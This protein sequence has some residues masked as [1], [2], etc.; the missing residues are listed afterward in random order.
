MN[1]KPAVLHAVGVH[2]IHA[3]LNARNA[4]GNLRESLR[5]QE[6]LFFVEWAMVRAH[7]LNQARLQR[8]PQHGQIALVAQR[9]RHNVLHAFHS[10]ALSVTLVE[11]KVGQHRFDVQVDAAHFGFHGRAQRRCA[12]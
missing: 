4:I 10:G 5:A 9:R 6:L 11:K 2:Q 12:R 3:I 8:I 7:S 1:I